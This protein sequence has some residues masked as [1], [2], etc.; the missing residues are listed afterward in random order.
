MLLLLLSPASHKI[1][2]SLWSLE[3]RCRLPAD[4]VA[5]AVSCRDYVAGA[6][7]NLAGPLVV[8]G[9]AFIEPGSPWENPFVEWFSSRVRVEFLAWRCS[10]A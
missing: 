5:S 3:V 10:R 8:R 4:G 7:K 2:R 6:Y 1:F 9:P